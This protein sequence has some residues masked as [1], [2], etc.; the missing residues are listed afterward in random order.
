MHNLGTRF[1]ATR[2]SAFCILA[3]SMVFA[4]S[5]AEKS[6]SNAP[7]SGTVTHVT[8]GD[9]LWI[10]PASGGKPVRVRIDG[11]DAPEICQT[12]GVAAKKALAA[13]LDKQTVTVQSSS[14]DSFGRLLAR[15]AITAKVRG[16]ADI[17]EWLVREGHAWSYRY[18]RDNGPY[19]KQQAAARA[20]RKGLFATA[21]PEEP[22]DFRKRHGACGE[23]AGP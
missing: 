14:R 8:D 21:R 12:Y 1:F 13:R 22:R 2:F 15:V 11:V 10:R 18:R 17:G 6:T 4:A 7:W 3:A 23:S 16:S 5:A 20:A 19:A 9:T